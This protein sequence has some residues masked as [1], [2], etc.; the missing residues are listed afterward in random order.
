MD[1]AKRTLTTVKIKTSLYIKLRKRLL[2]IGKSFSR[3][4]EDMIEDYLS[5]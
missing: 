3:W 4:V 5:R 1:R 2:E